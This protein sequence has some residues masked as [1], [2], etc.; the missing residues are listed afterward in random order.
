M[1][2]FELLSIAEP[3]LPIPGADPW[4]AQPGDPALNVMTDFRERTS[5]TVAESAP[6]DA[7]LE[8]MKH[9]GVRCAFSINE[10]DRVVGLVTSYDILGEKPVRHVQTVAGQRSDVLV[11]DIMVKITDWRVAD[12]HDLERST[13]DDV[14]RRFEE[15][16]LTHIPVVEVS[17][18]GQR[19]LRGLLSAAKVRRLLGRSSAG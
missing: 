10:A 14:R 8:H 2:T 12:A 19:H 15:S 16:A 5:I 18:N 17:Q 4:Y 3:E 1:K 6:I 13:V 7:A 9:A 11:R